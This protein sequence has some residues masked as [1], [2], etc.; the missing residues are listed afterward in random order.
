MQPGA[1][2][3][4]GGEEGSQ[5]TTSERGPAEVAAKEGEAE[6][7]PS[8]TVGGVV[9][10]YGSSSE[11]TLPAAD[12][13]CDP[14]GVVQ[15]AEETALKSAIAPHV[16]QTP[17]YAPEKCLARESV[18]SG[19]LSSPVTLGGNVEIFEDLEPP[20]ISESPEAVREPLPLLA[21]HEL[22]RPVITEQEIFGSSDELTSD[23]EGASGEGASD[24]GDAA[25]AEVKPAVEVSLEE[26]VRIEE[27]FVKAT[28]L[29]SSSARDLKSE[30]VGDTQGSFNVTFLL[31]S[32]PFQLMAGRERQL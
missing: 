23:G 27:E 19:D 5:E 11:A 24:G 28:N 6:K 15:H 14:Q 21:E 20:S 2:P 22:G 16:L 4:Q 17:L 8:E 3:L 7:G 32:F 31:P 26:L 18:Y 30:W 12:A 9:S 13:A 29:L 10:F 1:A 25:A